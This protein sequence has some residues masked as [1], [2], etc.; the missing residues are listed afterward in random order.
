M[1][2]RTEGDPRRTLT[3]DLQSPQMGLF[4]F[5]SAENSLQK[6]LHFCLFSGEEMAF[7]MPW[8]RLLQNLHI[9]LF[10]FIFSSVHSSHA[11]VAL[12]HSSLSEWQDGNHGLFQSTLYSSNSLSTDNT[13]IILASERTKRKD[14]TKLYNY[15]TGGWNISDEHYWA[16]S[17]FAPFILLSA[18]IS[19]INSFQSSDSLLHLMQFQSLS[20]LL[21][22]LLALEQPCY[23]SVAALA[24]LDR[25]DTPIL[26]ISM[27]FPS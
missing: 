1:R 2:Q 6:I 23:S 3:R 18:N 12:Y 19:S 21:H 25:E 27:R 5:V 26:A 14:P 8:R 17:F 15:Y 24:A 11:A 9:L 16:V 22:G 13:S 10:L 7:S 4:I 20:W